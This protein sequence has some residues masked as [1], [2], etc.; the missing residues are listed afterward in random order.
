[1]A[2]A[3]HPRRMKMCR[4][5][6]R[7]RRSLGAASPLI[8]LTWE[9]RAPRTVAT[10]TRLRFPRERLL[11]MATTGCRGGGGEQVDTLVERCAGLDVHKDSV[12]A[13]VRVPDGHGGRHAQ[14]RRFTT[15][16]AGL[17]LLAEWLASYRVTRVAGTHD[18]GVLAALAKGRPRSK[19]PALRA[20]LAGRFRTEHHEPVGRPDPGH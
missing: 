13:C 8:P 18:P 20:A 1:M 16:T 10:S 14:T 9:P 4:S 3:G 19:L 6:G 5:S 17:V 12:T 15:T 2:G 7:R 11:R